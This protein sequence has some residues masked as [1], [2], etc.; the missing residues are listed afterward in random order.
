MTTHNDEFSAALLESIDEAI[1]V[2]LSQEVLDAFHMNLKNKLSINPEE[3]PDNLPTVSIVLKKYFGPS[4]YTI[5]KSV[6]QRLYA[7]YGLDFQRKEGY[8]LTD[9]VAKARVDM[10]SRTPSHEVANV[11]L[12]LKNDFNPLLVE[13]VKEA[14][15]DALGKEQAKLAFRFIERDV[16]FEKLPNQLPTFYMALKK[17]FGKNCGTIETAIARKLYQKLSLEFIE[18][19]NT[20]LA[21]YVEEAFINITRR[22]HQGFVNIYDKMERQ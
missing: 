16:S 4:A 3:I 18:T 2:L 19:P 6:A 21:R 10:A 22:E 7:K 13:S 17:N 14:I 20:E 12:P 15:E 11:N 9:Y 5:E 8:E 1:R